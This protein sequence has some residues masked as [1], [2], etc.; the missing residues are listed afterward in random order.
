MIYFYAISTKR[1]NPQNPKTS[2]QPFWSFLWKEYRI[3]DFIFFK[4]NLPA[5]VLIC[6]GVLY[7]INCNIYSDNENMFRLNSQ[8]I[9]D[10]IRKALRILLL[11]C[12]AF[13]LIQ[14][15]FK[16]NHFWLY[17]FIVFLVFFLAHYFLP[18]ITSCFYPSSSGFV[19][20]T[21][22]YLFSCF[23]YTKYN[24]DDDNIQ[25]YIVC[26][27]LI[28]SGILLFFKFP[29]NHWVSFTF[30]ILIFCIIIYLLWNFYDRSIESYAF[31]HHFSTL[32]FYKFSFDIYEHNW[33]V[34]QDWATMVCE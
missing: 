31:V 2:E 3:P 5:L 29:Y 15:P 26:I 17:F 12:M 21:S 20:T 19:Y 13:Y 8:D 34:N 28:L 7:M 24:N 1:Y 33:F 18:R 23:Q 14:I 30:G 6:L 25:Q 9:P 10:K 16:L 32:D 27:F 4:F 22:Y 11:P